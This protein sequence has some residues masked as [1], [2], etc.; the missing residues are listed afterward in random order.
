MEDIFVYIT[1]AVLVCLCLMA[2]CILTAICCTQDNEER[3][4]LVDVEKAETA[5]LTQDVSKRC[6][7]ANYG[8]FLNF[9]RLHPVQA[10]RPYHHHHHRHHRHHRHHHH[11]HHHRHHHH[12]SR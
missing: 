10:S 3:K 5:V 2:C 11:H 7:A 9:Q 1:S 4:N 6:S 8:T 12:V